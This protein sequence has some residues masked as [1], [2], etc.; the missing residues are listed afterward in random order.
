M[1]GAVPCIDHESL[2]PSLQHVLSSLHL[3]DETEVSNMVT[4]VLSSSLN[5]T[6]GCLTTKTHAPNYE[7]TLPSI[8]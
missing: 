7:I 8:H 4:E 1:L 3:A 6:L 5:Q 2:A